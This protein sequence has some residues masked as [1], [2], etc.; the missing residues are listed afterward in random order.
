MF[1]VVSKMFNIAGNEVQETRN[2]KR[3]VIRVTI[4]LRCD[5]ERGVIWGY[6]KHRYSKTVKNRGIIWGFVMTA[7]HNK[8][9]V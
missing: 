7:I 9:G 1:Y 8:K 5:I 6:K 3:G 2:N 4:K